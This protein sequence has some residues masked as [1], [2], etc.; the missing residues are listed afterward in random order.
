MYERKKHLE[1]IA[2]DVM[3][4]AHSRATR[5]R[6][7]MIQGGEK[8]FSSRACVREAKEVEPGHH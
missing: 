1:K 4:L 6:K 5:D 7:V 2:A 3:P 8:N